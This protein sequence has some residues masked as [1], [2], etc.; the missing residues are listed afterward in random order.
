MLH[1]FNLGFGDRRVHYV[2]CLDS[3]SFGLI[4]LL[5]LSK[6]KQPLFVCIRLLYESGFHL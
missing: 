5:D 3:L 1:L 4:E 2:D 6:F